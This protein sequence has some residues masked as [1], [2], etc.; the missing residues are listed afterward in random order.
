M[1]ALRKGSKVDES[2]ALYNTALITAQSP[3]SFIVYAPVLMRGPILTLWGIV[4][5]C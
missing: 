4:S 3:D 5:R 1:R 2:A